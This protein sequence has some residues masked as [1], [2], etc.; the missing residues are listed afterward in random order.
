MVKECSVLLVLIHKGERVQIRLV[1]HLSHRAKANRL[2]NRLRDGPRVRV[3]PR[4]NT[5][6]GEI[7]SRTQSWMWRV[8][9]EA[10]C[11]PPSRPFLK[12]KR[13]YLLYER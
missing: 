4:L 3:W 13:Q 10:Y 5:N 6:L 11:A 2:P 9:T 8:N 7:D 12:H 1:R